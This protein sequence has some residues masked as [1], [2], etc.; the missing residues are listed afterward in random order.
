MP[1]DPDRAYCCS[2][3]NYIFN[4]DIL[5]NALIQAERNKEYD[6]GK[7]VIPN[8]LNAG[9][10]LFAY[11]FETNIIPGSRPYEELGYWRDVGTIKAFWDAHQDMLGKPLFWMFV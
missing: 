10:K 6:F 4:T 3:G 5:I 8:L 9:K 1:D 11:D 2:M 7:Q